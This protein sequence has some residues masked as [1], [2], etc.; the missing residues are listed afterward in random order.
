M[1]QFD[2]VHEYSFGEGAVHLHYCQDHETL[3]IVNHIGGQ[4]NRLM[5][6][7]PKD[8]INDFRLELNK[9]NLEVVTSDDS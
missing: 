5:L 6:D 2:T 9:E 1:M 7:I 3:I 8:S 4:T